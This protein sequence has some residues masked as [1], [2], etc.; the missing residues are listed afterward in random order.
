MRTVR[1]VRYESGKFQVNIDDTFTGDS[2]IIDSERFNK[3][4]LSIEGYQSLSKVREI[5]NSEKPL[6]LF[7]QQ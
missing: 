7:S 3:K 1:I 2:I 5:I 6:Y 4:A